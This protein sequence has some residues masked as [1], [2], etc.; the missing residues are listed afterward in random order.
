VGDGA[1]PY[2]SRPVAGS[3]V[4][5]TP[6]DL[7][8]K[9]GAFDL[10]PCAGPSPRPWPTARKHIE[11][12]EDGLTTIWDGR[13][14]CNPPFGSQTWAWL[15]RMA[16]HG[17]GVALAFARTETEGF[18]RWV[19]DR[20]DSVLFLARRPHFH[21]PDGRRAGG[22]SGGPI[23]LIAYGANNTDALASSGIDGALVRRIEQERIAA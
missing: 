22:N 6:P 19:W 5:L 4:W 16:E 1:H 2:R 8:E 23:V 13:V 20:A 11:L 21:Y 17:N 7:L 15:Q 10:D 18:Q 14:W 12:P 3:H 9:L